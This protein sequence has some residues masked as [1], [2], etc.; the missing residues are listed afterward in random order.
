MLAGGLQLGDDVRF[1]GEVS[2]SAVPALLGQ[3]DVALMP[4]V[5]EGFG[6]VARKSGD[7]RQGRRPAYRERRG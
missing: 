5:G 2:P 4:A 7:E 1:L 6:L 3:A